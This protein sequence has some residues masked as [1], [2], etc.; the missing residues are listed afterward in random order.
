MT[1]RNVNRGDFVQPAGAVTA[2]PLLSV[3]RMDVVRIFVE[4]PE[5]ESPWV[6]AG[7]MGYVEVEGIPDRTVEGKV[8]RTSWALV[9]QSDLAATELDLPNP[10][11]SLR[12]GMYATAH[13]VLQERPNAYVLPLTAIVRDG[14]QAFCWVAQ[15]G[16]AVRTPIVVGLHVGNEVEVSAGL[17]GDELVVQ[18]QVGSLQ[19]GQII[20][21]A[22]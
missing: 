20:E 19:E 15:G 22:Q 16:R 21:A 3:A 14:K 4:V 1:E 10:N 2:K 9:G 6:E 18:S 7:R 17:K 11:G 5:R 12:P 8:T 13:I